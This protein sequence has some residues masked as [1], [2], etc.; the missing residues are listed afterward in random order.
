MRSSPSQEFVEG[1]VTLVEL[2]EGS[3]YVW[4]GSDSTGEDY[5]GTST[6]RVVAYEVVDDLQAFVRSRGWERIAHLDVDDGSRLD[7]RPVQAWLRGHVALDANA[8]ISVWNFAE[9]VLRSTSGDSLTSGRVTNGIHAHL[10]ELAV[11]WLAHRQTPS[12]WRVH[13]LRRLRLVLD[14]AVR[15]TWNELSPQPA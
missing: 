6:G 9:D 12:S 3:R 11:P 10:T 1:W 7:F 5:L 13:D 2:V 4:W 14:R 15:I 8:A